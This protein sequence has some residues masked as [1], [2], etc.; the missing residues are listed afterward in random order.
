MFRR[1]AIGP[2]IAA[3]APSMRQKRFP[4]GS[5]EQYAQGTADLHR[6]Y[7]DERPKE[8]SFYDRHT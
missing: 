3:R 6:S 2:Q 1:G 4:R 7:A 5:E 8:A